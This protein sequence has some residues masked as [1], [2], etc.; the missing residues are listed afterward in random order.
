LSRRLGG[1]RLACLALA[2][3]LAGCGRFDARDWARV[4]EVTPSFLITQ[5]AGDAALAGDHHGR[6]A[7][8][9]VT[10]GPRGQDLWLS[11]SSDSGATFAPA[12]R[13]NPREGG[14]ASQAESRPVPVFGPG[15]ELLVVWS[16]RRGHDPMVADL[17]ASAVAAGGGPPA[18][19]VVINDDAPDSL[20]TY[21]GFAAVT[22]LPSGGV[23]AAWM[24]HREGMRQGESP[25]HA[26]SIF[27]AVSGDGGATWSDNRS[28]TDHACP[29]CRPAAIGDASGV[30]AVAYRAE[31]GD[32]REPALAL[33]RDRGASFPLDSVV[34]ADGWRLPVCP[35]DGPALSLDAAGGGQYA[36]Y[37][38][39]GE[40]G[41]WITPWH[42]STGLAGARRPLS[43]GLTRPAHPRLSTLGD[44]TLI[45][46][47]G[48]PGSDS[49]RRVVA[50]R[51]LDPDGTLTPWVF[52]GAEAGDAWLA[53]PGGG[54]ALV[55]WSERA[56]GTDRVRVA[57]ITRRKR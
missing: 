4:R 6:V 32:R 25:G 36:W 42:P 22:F 26:A 46:I 21:H 39:A 57:R 54:T 2:A 9:W 11:L 24:D 55:C 37:S 15:G 48:S 41:V 16:E 23:F 17:V 33:S 8:T 12:V 44:A 38:G 52:L 20:P 5:A 34:V 19:P 45:A 1:L 3:L 51:T 47:E 14:V 28:L 31:Q 56:D 18:A 13:V 53:T 40:G 29:C 10:S 30:V 7:L 27:Y 50:V 49:T 43:D 35:V